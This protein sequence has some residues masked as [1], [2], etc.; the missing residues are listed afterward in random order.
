M[1]VNVK[2]F[3]VPHETGK[4]PLPFSMVLCYYIYDGILTFSVARGPV[5]CE[6]LIKQR[7][8]LKIQT[9]LTLRSIIC[10]TIP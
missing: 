6:R 1:D 7:E 5:P 10:F 9:Y 4:I 2:R 3:F 8:T